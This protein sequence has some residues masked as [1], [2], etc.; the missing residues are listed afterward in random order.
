MHDHFIAVTDNVAERVTASREQIPILRR[1]FG[2]VSCL[3]FQEF[4][5]HAAGFIHIEFVAEFITPA[6]R[7]LPRIQGGGS[8]TV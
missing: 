2:G 7:E 4:C 1:V 3:I 8:M 5:G 6:Q